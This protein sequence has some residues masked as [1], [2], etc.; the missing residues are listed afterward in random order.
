MTTDSEIKMKNDIDLIRVEVKLTS[1]QV[2]FI[3][4]KL[5]TAGSDLLSMQSLIYYLLE[6]AFPNL[7]KR[8]VSPP[9]SRG[10]GRKIGSKNKPKKISRSDQLYFLDEI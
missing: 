4:S 10:Q 3:R 7:P 1:E 2:N 6:S 5:N 9:Y 8:T